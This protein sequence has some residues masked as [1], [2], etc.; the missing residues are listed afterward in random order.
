M[1][2]MAR[3]RWDPQ[4]QHIPPLKPIS[5]I[6]IV[7]WPETKRPQNRP[8]V[9]GVLFAIRNGGG[10]I[11]SSATHVKER[12]G[13]MY[14]WV[15]VITLESMTDLEGDGR[16]LEETVRPGSEPSNQVVVAKPY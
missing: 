16:R 13:P 9:L 10:M 2:C 4:N 1:L 5:A 14:L 8:C 15:L 7:P 12:R 6:E 3:D 11:E